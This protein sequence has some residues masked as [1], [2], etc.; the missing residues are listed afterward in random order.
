MAVPAHHLRRLAGRL[1]PWLGCRAICRD[2]AGLIWRVC[3]RGQVG[4]GFHPRQFRSSGLTRVAPDGRCRDHERP[5]V[6]AG[7]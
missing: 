2:G 5:R 7:R 6:N 3:R 4:V 1:E